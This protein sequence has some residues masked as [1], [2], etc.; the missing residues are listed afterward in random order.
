MNKI[1]KIIL[2]LS[3]L[4]FILAAVV[5][6]G[7]MMFFTTVEMEEGSSNSYYDY[8]VTIETD[9]PLENVT[10]YLPVPAFE[11]RSLVGEEMVTKDFY[12]KAPEW[13]FSLVDTEYGTMLSITN[14]MII[15]MYRSLPTPVSEDED[16]DGIEQEMIVVES[17]EYSEETPVLHPID[18]SIGTSAD[19]ELNTRNPMGNESLLLPKYD[20]MASEPADTIQ[21]PEHIDPEYYGYESRIFASYNTSS[22][23]TVRITVD[24]EGVNSW[25]VGGWRSN[26]YQDTVSIL[27]NGGQNGWM[28][29]QGTMVTSD[30]IYEE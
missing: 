14:S 3:I 26:S 2:G 10:L 7:S 28:N 24:M 22:D 11:N 5:V 6:V 23:A 25:W 12:N 29:V 16:I 13:N 4:I 9:R 19:H 27:L 17:N 20:L 30:G 21:E 8:S 18:L 15:P 1:G